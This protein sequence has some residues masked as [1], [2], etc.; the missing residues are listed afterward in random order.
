MKL[1]NFD[2]SESSCTIELQGLGHCW[3]L[4][5]CAGFTGF[6]FSPE[7][8]ELILEWRVASA[9]ENPWGSLGNRAR[10]CQLRFRG[11]SFLS[12]SPRDAACPSSEALC[13]AG[14]SK[15]IPGEREYPHKDRWEPDEPFHLLFEFQDERTL[16][17][18]AAAV[19]LEVID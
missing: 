12:M 1:E 5:N 19:R 8:D 4:H 10:G 18:G 17:I 2:L 14:L 7:R 3:D 6:A 16:E 11:I 15:V 9:Q 13:L